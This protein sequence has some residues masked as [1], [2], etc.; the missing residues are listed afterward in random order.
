[1]IRAIVQNSSDLSSKAPQSLY[2]YSRTQIG[3]K[4]QFG[5][6][7]DDINIFLME[8]DVNLWAKWKTTSVFR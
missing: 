7:E 4:P 2:E 3:R 8:D 5:K 1:M 6:M